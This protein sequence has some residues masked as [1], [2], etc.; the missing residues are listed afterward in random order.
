MRHINA[1]TD[2]DGSIY[3]RSLT[4]PPQSNVHFLIYFIQHFKRTKRE[5]KST[6]KVTLPL[7]HF[8]IAFC[9]NA[10]HT[11]NQKLSE[12]MII[13]SSQENDAIKMSTISSVFLSLLRKRNVVASFYLI[14]F[15]Q[16]MLFISCAD[17]H[18]EYALESRVLKNLMRSTYVNISFSHD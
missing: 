2:V 16:S 6:W 10:M 14:F 7:F 12:K 17:S 8:L 18:V 15:S 13:G 4:F 5:K 11:Q 9:M 1:N 3:A